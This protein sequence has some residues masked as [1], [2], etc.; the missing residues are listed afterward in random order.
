MAILA[1]LRRQ[2]P[3]D[4]ALQTDWQSLLESLKLANI[5]PEPLLGELEVD[6]KI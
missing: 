4:A 3:R 5:V 6:T 2:R 1:Q